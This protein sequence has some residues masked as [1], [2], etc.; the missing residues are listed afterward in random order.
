[1][2]LKATECKRYKECSTRERKGI[3]S[4]RLFYWVSELRT[5]HSRKFK[6]HITNKL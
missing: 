1:M 3:C 6:A 5:T 4:I 2:V